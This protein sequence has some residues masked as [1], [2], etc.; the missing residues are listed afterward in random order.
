[1]DLE[2]ISPYLDNADASAPVAELIERFRPRQWR[3]L[4]P[5]ER[6]AARCRESLFDWVEELGGQWGR[7]PGELTSGGDQQAKQRT[8]H[9]KTYRFFDTDRE[10]IFVGSFNLT[11]PAHDAAGNVESGVLIEGPPGRKRRQFWLRRVTERPAFA[12]ATG[13]EE[14]E[15]Y[16]AIPLAVRYDWGTGIAEVLWT[17]RGASTHLIAED[18]GVS[19]FEVTDL[20][21]GDWWQLAAEQADELSRRLRHSSMF[22][23]RDGDRQGIVLVLETGMAHRPSLLLD[24]SPADIL[25]F[26]SLLSTEQRDAYLAEHAERLMDAGEAAHLG[27]Y[28]EVRSGTTE[29]IFDRFA[30]MFHGF[31][32]LARSIVEDLRD[33][34]TEEARFRMFGAKYD[35]LPVLIE[36]V[37]RDTTGDLVDRYLMTLCGRQIADRVRRDWPDFWAGE[38]SGAARLERALAA[39][40]DIRAQIIER[41]G[42]DMSQFLDWYEAQYLREVAEI[43]T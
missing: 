34:R 1:M 35:S 28:S 17:G 32:S 15:D 16:D 20:E 36:Q 14:A 42:T 11:R 40:A 38:R 41:N 29:S 31:A 37:A 6:D 26:W 23:V 5:E 4:L 7:L 12:Q 21:P 30:G 24:L 2:I 33:G 27:L 10:F 43:H 22:T 25:R 9:A 13:E 39:Q 3:I 8:V 19:V 18:H